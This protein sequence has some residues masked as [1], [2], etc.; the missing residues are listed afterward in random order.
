MGQ[1]GGP[2]QIRIRECNTGKSWTC[3]D[4]NRNQISMTARGDEWLNLTRRDP[5]LK[6]RAR[7]SSDF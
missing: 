3:S 2:Y 4:Q 5:C 1:L 6:I 7:E